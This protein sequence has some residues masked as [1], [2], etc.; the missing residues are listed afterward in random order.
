MKYI[1]HTIK[2]VPYGKS[3]SRGDIDAAERWTEN[4]QKQTQG[5]GRVKEACVMK[6]TFLLPPEKFPA[7]FPYGSDLDNL[8]KR[9]L[10][11]LNETIFS[12]A[13]GLDSCVVSMTVMKTKVESIDEAGVHFE[14][15]SVA[16][17]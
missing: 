4:I 17:R 7:D 14:V 12:E 9:F 1:N 6:V 5:L 3:K 10:D 15:M 8:L 11:A 13:P 16:V 2:G